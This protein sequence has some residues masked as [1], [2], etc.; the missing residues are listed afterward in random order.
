MNIITHF[1]SVHN[2]TNSYTYHNS[3]FGSRTGHIAIKSSRAPPEGTNKKPRPGGHPDTAIAKPTT[4]K[5][6]P[7]LPF[8]DTMPACAKQ[9]AK[10]S[11]RTS[12][13]YTKGELT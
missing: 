4:L 1:H 8:H 13:S 9:A 3:W 7:V 11:S 2:T 12:T 10:G 6:K 5:S